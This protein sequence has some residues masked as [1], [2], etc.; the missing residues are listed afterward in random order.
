MPAC[1]A[2]KQ[3]LRDTGTGGESERVKLK[4]MVRVEAVEYDAE[5]EVASHAVD[6]SAAGEAGQRRRLGQVSVRFQSPACS[7]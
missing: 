5:G 3:V 7:S 1:L 6:Y 2:A 4:L